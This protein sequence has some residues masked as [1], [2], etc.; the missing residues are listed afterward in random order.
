MAGGLRGSRERAAESAGNPAQ[1]TFG[2]LA[3]GGTGAA[4]AVGIMLGSS[5]FT[6][7]S[8]AQIAVACTSRA[9]GGSTAGIEW[10]GFAG[11]AQHTAVASA[12]AQPLKRI[13]WRAKVDRSP[14]V[15]GQLVSNHGSPMITATNTVLVPTRVSARAGFRVIA[16]SGASGERRWS[17]DTDYQPAVFAHAATNATPALP[18]VLIPS[19]YL[20]VAG[21]GGTVLMR[22]QRLPIAR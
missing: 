11:N 6:P 15:Q 20:A 4:A 19:G 16:Y 7:A 17:L 5:F 10:A 8:S 14:N 22:G 2:S 21:A 9:V 13:R 1:R 3:G 18:A 12:R